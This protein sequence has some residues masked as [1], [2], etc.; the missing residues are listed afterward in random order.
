MNAT[1]RDGSADRRSVLIVEDEPSI[2]ET[3]AEL[4]EVPGVDTVRAASLVEAQ[5]ALGERRFDLV[6]T[7]IRLA[8]KVE[9]DDGDSVLDDGGQRRH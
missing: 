2:G 3:L 9:R 8:G 7:D 5:R 4:F 1:E 6:V